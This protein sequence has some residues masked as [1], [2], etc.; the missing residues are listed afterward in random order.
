MSVCTVKSQRVVT[1]PPSYNIRLVI[2]PLMISFDFKMPIYQQVQIWLISVC[3][4]L[5]SSSSKTLNP[6]TK[7][8]TALCASFQSWIYFIFHYLGLIVNKL[9][10]WALDM[11]PSG[12]VFSTEFLSCWWVCFW[13]TSGCLLR[14][15][16]LPYK[17]LVYV[18]P[19]FIF[20]HHFSSSPHLNV[21]LFVRGIVSLCYA[22][23]TLKGTQK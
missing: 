13:S 23:M 10:P 12:S 20:Y 11:K 22:F 21:T 15:T 7:W 9:W 19:F 16:H 5:N 3:L 2:I 6:T 14:P 18:I 1:H 4:D 17:G 8:Y